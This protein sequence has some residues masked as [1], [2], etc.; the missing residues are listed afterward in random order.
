MHPTFSSNQPKRSLARARAMLRLVMHQH[1]ATMKANSTPTAVPMASASASTVASS[2]GMGFL[3]QKA[4]EKI[5]I[6]KITK[7]FA[8][9]VPQSGRKFFSCPNGTFFG[10]FAHWWTTPSSTKAQFTSAPGK[11]SVDSVGSFHEDVG[12]GKNLSGI[13]YNFSSL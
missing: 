7:L 12:A 1:W 11:I 13:R 2:S 8:A 4:N 10:A 9:A 6:D 3:R 5:T